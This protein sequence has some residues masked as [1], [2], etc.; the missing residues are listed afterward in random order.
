[1]MQV[2]AVLA[3]AIGAALWR[4]YAPWDPNNPFLALIAD[5][6]PG[7]TRSLVLGLRGRLGRHTVLPSP[8]NRHGHRTVVRALLAGGAPAGAA[9]VSGGS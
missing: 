4:W 6:S 1:M 2:L 3:A 7:W 9:A 8:I 5:R